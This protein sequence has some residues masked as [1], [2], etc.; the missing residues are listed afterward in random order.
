[1]TCNVAR[2]QCDGYNLKDLSVSWSAK[3]PAR[4]LY[5]EDTNKDKIVESVV[6][7]DKITKCDPLKTCCKLS[8][9]SYGC[10]SV[11]IKTFLH[12]IE[13]YLKIQIKF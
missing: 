2:Q 4:Q 11:S 6:C 7:D 8:D 3:I 5:N 10:C 12:I 9:E 1:M 13:N